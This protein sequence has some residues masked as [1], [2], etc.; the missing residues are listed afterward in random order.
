VVAVDIRAMRTGDRILLNE[1]P[2]MTRLLVSV[3][4]IVEL[5][6]GLYQGLVGVADQ[7]P[8]HTFDNSTSAMTAGNR[9]GEGAIWISF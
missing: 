3:V 1:L 8:L 7:D 4:I 9:S 5:C 6:K 2:R